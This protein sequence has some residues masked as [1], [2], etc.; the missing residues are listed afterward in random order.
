MK[1]LGK[2]KK[3]IGWEISRDLKAGTLKSDQKRYIQDLLESKGITSCYPNFL[4]VK[5]SSTLFLDQAG[6]YQQADLTKYQR[7][8]G[9]LIYLTYGTQPD[10]NA[11]ARAPAYKTHVVPGSPT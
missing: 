1:D 2:A 3:I 7:L 11:V 6:Y 8:I 5:A 4:S 9:K 10:C